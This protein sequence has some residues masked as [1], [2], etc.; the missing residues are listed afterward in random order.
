MVVWVQW[1]GS[2]WQ[3]YKAERHGGSWSTPTSLSDHL[4][5]AG[6]D[7]KFPQISLNDAGDAVVVWRQ[8]DGSNNQIY[9]A[10]YR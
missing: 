1:D 6:T 9:K 10:E 7:A 8:H 4:S 3:V 5:E 2:N